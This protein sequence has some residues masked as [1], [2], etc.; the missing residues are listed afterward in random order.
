M[1]VDVGTE[2]SIFQSGQK[3]RY[4][5]TIPFSKEN[6]DISWGLEIEGILTLMWLKEHGEIHYVKNRGY[7]ADRLQ[8]WL[9]H[10][11]FPILLELRGIYNILH[12]GSVEIAGQPVLFSAPSF[13]GKSTMTDY[14]IQQGHMMLSDDALGIEKRETTYYAISS[15]PFYRPYRKPEELGYFVENFSTKAKP[16]SRVYLL[17]KSHAASQIVIRELLGIE[18]FK[19]YHYS[20]FISFEFMKQERFEFFSEM[21]KRIPMYEITFPHDLQKLPEAYQAIVHHF[22]DQ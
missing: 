21:A 12:V 7:S 3:A 22:R 19:T 18:K 4:F 5:S 1:D 15:Y 14:F 9:Y 6:Q 11:F 16:I 2:S 13:G 8:F 20:S 10:T 17:N